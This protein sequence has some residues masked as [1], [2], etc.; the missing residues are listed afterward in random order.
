[1]VD[2]AIDTNGDVYAAGFFSEIGGVTT[3]GIARWDSSQWNSVGGGV[4]GVVSDVLVHSDGDIYI[5]GGFTMAGGTPALFVARWDGTQ[6]HPMGDLNDVATLAE[7]PT[8]DV[9]A[10]GVG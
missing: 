2:V 3:T 10:G 5:A 1:M 8:G 6:W 4:N 9:Y 7:S